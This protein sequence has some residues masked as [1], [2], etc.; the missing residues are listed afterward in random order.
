MLVV[1]NDKDPI[2]HAN[3]FAATPCQLKATT[4]LSSGGNGLLRLDPC[5]MAT[6]ASTLT[7]LRELICGTPPWGSHQNTL[8]S[9]F[10]MAEPGIVIKCFTRRTYLL[11]PAKSSY[12]SECRLE[13]SCDK[14]LYLTGYLVL[15]HEAKAGVRTR[16]LPNSTMMILLGTRLHYWTI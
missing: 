4:P 5:R 6:R 3:T 12:K 14:G 1:L 7:Y 9:S 11:G 8:Q 10:Y 13:S 2:V 16:T 15:A